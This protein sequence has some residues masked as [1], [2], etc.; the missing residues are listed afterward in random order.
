MQNHSKK[1]TKKVILVL[2]A[3]IVLFAV[4]IFILEKTHVINLYEKKQNTSDE[5]AQTTSDQPTAQ[6]D[7]NDG[8]F[9]EPGSSE[10][11]DKGSATVNDNNGNI[12]GNTDTSKPTV[13]STGEITLYTPKANS[14]ISS[15]Q[16]ISGLSS[17]PSVSFR[18]IDDVSGVIASG[19]IK[20]VNGKFSGKLSF[21]TSAK[22]GRIDIY[23]TRNDGVEYSNIEVPVSFK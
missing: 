22:T 23:A 11:E 3:T 19:S 9:R 5:N 20:V 6:S 1:K 4:V 2:I 13:S 10:S 16:E 8:N 12:D 7:Y 14:T 17:L 15:G 18:I 21:N